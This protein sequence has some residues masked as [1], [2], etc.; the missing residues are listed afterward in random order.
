MGF[1]DQAIEKPEFYV[2]ISKEADLY[3]TPLKLIHNKISPAPVAL[4]QEMF[5][6]EQQTTELVMELIKEIEALERP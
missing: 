3:I 6:E 2:L 4:D 1:F 5:Q